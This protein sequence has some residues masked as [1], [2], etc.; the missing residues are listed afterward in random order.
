MS[1]CRFQNTE[2]DFE[3]CVNAIGECES[4]SDFSS[5]EQRAAES[6]RELAEQYIEWYDSALAETEEC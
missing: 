3:D 2:S 5:R 1:Y 4:L 6:L